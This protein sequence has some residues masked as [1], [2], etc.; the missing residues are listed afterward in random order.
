[1]IHVSTKRVVWNIDERKRM[2]GERILTEHGVAFKRRRAHKG[3]LVTEIYLSDAVSNSCPHLF[4]IS[5]AFKFIRHRLSVF[6][7]VEVGSVSFDDVVGRAIDGDEVE[8]R[9]LVRQPRW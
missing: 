8:E 4:D 2:A 5:G 1:M 7:S 9:F 6:D 3:E